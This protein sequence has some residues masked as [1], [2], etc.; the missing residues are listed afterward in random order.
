[1]RLFKNVRRGCCGSRVV[2]GYILLAV[3]I[4]LAVVGMAGAASEPKTVAEIALYQ[5]PDREKM[6]IEGA[7]KEA[8]L[9]FYNSHTGFR[10]VAQEFEK[11]YPFINVSEWRSESKE[12]FKRVM[13]EYA[14]GRFLVDVVETTDLM[15]FLQ[16]EGILQEYYSPH[17]LYYGDEYKA[18]GKT[19]VYYLADREIYIGLGFNTEHVPLAE[20][21]KSL[22]DLLDPRWKGKMS[23]TGTK[24]GTTWLGNAL[25]VMGR[26]F[27]EKLSH[28]DVKVQNISGA[29]LAGLV[30]SGEVP[31]SPSIFRDNIF[32]AKKKGAPVE[33]RPLEPVVTN[34]GCSGITTKAPHP[35]A[36]LLFLD[37]LHSKEGQQVV[38]KSGPSSPRG[39]MGSMGSLETKFKKTIWESKYS[40][41]EFEKKFT[42]WENLLR[43]LFIKGK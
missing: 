5:G 4:S 34:I 3:T 26:D 35:Y 1:M 13:E 28:Q 24:T 18:K 14:A 15:A 17:M 8:Q 10:T 21:P 43:K 39:D 42:E 23:I 19:G 30:A 41:E 32:V 37:Y 31:L 40:P 20:A 9:T 33:W 36:A 38:M 22:K 12:L 7:K 16:R 27:I 29:A 25:E 2:I 6:L 11:K